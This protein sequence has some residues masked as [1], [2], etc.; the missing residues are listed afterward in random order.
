MSLMHQSPSITYE[1]IQRGAHTRFGIDFGDG[2]LIPVQSWISV[3]LDTANN[4][5]QKDVLYLR[6]NANVVI[7]IIK[8]ILTPKGWD[9]L[10]LQ[11]HKFAFSDLPG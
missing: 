11:Q 3:T 8:N 4:V 10:M 6:F 7:E 9:D 1:I 2:A 5:G